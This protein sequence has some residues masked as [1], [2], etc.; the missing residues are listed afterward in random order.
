MVFTTGSI[1][2]RYL[3]LNSRYNRQE[4]KEI[5]KFPSELIFVNIVQ[6]EIVNRVEFDGL[7]VDENT[8][9]VYGEIYFNQKE[10]NLIGLNDKGGVLISN[11]E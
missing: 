2:I 8:G 6:N 10:K 5:E 4:E 11:L 3:C 1:H 7:E 9:E